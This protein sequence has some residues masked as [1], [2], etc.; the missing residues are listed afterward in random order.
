MIR[1][2]KEPRRATLRPSREPS[3]K[4][5][6][7]E[8]IKAFAEATGM[9]LAEAATQLNKAAT[10]VFFRQGLESCRIHTRLTLELALLAYLNAQPLPRMSKHT[11][12]KFN[13][14]VLPYAECIREDKI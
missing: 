11:A 3:P 6:A 12:A 8:E 4:V 2:S 14:F 7:I 13:T 5:P 9:G 1:P 10:E